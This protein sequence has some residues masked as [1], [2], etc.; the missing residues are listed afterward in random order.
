MLCSLGLP[1]AQ[2]RPV[3]QIHTT[4]LVPATRLRDPVD[5]QT[6]RMLEGPF[7]FY[8]GA[9]TITDADLARSISTGI[10]VDGGGHEHIVATAP[11]G[12]TAPQAGTMAGGSRTTSECCRPATNLMLGY[13]S[14]NDREFYARRFRNM[15]GSVEPE[16]LTACQFG[17]YARGCGT[18]RAR[19]RSA[20]RAILAGCLGSST[21]S[22]EAV[23]NWACTTRTSHLRTIARSRQH[24]DQLFTPAA[25]RL[26]GR[27]GSR[28]LAERSHRVD[29]RSELP[30][31]DGRGKVGE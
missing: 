1:I 2:S 19:G 18:A 20:N 27:V 4:S 3:V 11:S 7:A 13:A 24:P 10:E 14:F 9:A 29:D 21:A 17:L 12:S 16:R 8:R 23:V 26:E 30:A 22:D 28:H 6:Q 5:L 31:I 15:K 25:A